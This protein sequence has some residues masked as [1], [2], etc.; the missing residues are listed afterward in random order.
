MIGRALPPGKRRGPGSAKPERPPGAEAVGPV[1]GRLL[2]DLR[3]EE[4][5]REGPLA[6][7]WDKAAGPELA[8]RARPVSF[9]TGL[10]VVEVDGAP[11]LQEVRGFRAKALLEAL[12]GHPGGGKVREIRFV[13]AGRSGGGE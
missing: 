13:P 6:A 11:L 10:L 1:L 8:A 7:A 9:R 3:L 4:R 5:N 2:R 12:R